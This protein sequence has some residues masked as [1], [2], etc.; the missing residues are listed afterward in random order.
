MT[1][2]YVN[3]VDEIFALFLAAWQASA[4][5]I[6]GYTPVVY[7]PG[8][9]EPTSPDL[10]K[11]WARASQQTVRE[12]QATLSEP[13]QA[14]KKRYQ[15]DGLV[16]VQIFCPPAASGA[17]LK[18]RQLGEI[19]KNAFRGKQTSSNVWFRNARIQELAPEPAWLRFNVVAEY[20]Y[21]EIG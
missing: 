20:Q 17:M 8:V 10:T 11:F 7:W 3:A 16:F 15:N 4:P 18:G 6:V 21:D 13:D 14:G 9:V 2:G 19:A 5:G 12:E 1:T